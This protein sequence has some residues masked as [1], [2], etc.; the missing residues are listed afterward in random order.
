M[1]IRSKIPGTHFNV[2]YDGKFFVYNNMAVRNFSLHDFGFSNVKALGKDKA[3]TLYLGA[4]YT[5]RSN[6]DDYKYYQYNQFF[7]YSSLY[8]DLDFLFLKSG[9][10]FRY[11]NY[12]NV[13]D[14]SN[15]RHYFFLQLNKSFKT[16]T[17]LIIEADYGYKS[18]AGQQLFTDTLTV[19]KGFGRRQNTTIQTT[20][21]SSEIPSLSQAVLLARIAQSLH[22]RVGVYIQYRKQISLTDETIYQNSDAYYQDEELFDDPFS[23]ESD[24]YSCQLTWLMPWL[25]RAKVG[26]TFSSKTYVSEQA[27]ISETDS[28]GLGGDRKDDKTYYFVNVTKSFQINKSWLRTLVFELNYNLVKNV[29]NSYWYNFK[30]SILG[31]SIQLKF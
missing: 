22:D 2:F 28:G 15:S 18:F 12:A 17:S 26:G 25:M 14:L 10:N 6:T 4:E 20:V 7:A 11:R 27:Y 21:S 19:T 9:Y 24:N 31:G 23:Y 3:H 29:S 8:L 1:Y 16:R 13:P 5:I 30:N